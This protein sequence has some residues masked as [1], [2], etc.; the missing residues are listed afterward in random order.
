MLQELDRI[1]RQTDQRDA[2]VVRKDCTMFGNDLMKQAS[3]LIQEAE[4]MAKKNKK[5]H[6]TLIA[7]ITS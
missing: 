6:V 3:S 7:I 4:K 5:N 2:T 1:S